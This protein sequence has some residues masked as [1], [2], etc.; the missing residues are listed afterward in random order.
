[1]PLF[2]VTGLGRDVILRANDEGSA[3]E[4]MAGKGKDKNEDWL[5]QDHGLVTQLQTDGSTQVMWD[6]DAPKE[7]FAAP[8]AK[9]EKSPS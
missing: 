9:G 1:M 6:S 2:R 7:E 3:R 8:K 5:S 4:F